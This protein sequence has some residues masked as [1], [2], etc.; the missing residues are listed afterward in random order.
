MQVLL[1]SVLCWIILNSQWH[2]TSRWDSSWY[3]RS[4]LFYEN[5]YVCVDKLIFDFYKIYSITGS[6][7]ET[8]IWDSIANAVSKEFPY[9]TLQGNSFK[10]S[11][12][13]E[14]VNLD[15]YIFHLAPMMMWKIFLENYH[16][17]REKWESLAKKGEICLYI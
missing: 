10:L 17:P 16:S 3:S 1:M 4:K 5:K 11:I 12:N 8:N 13:F 6:I 2:N 7:L 14:I 9:Q 15:C